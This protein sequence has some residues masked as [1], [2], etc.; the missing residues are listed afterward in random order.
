MATPTQVP[1]P[2]AATAP[3]QPRALFVWLMRGGAI[4]L[5]LVLAFLGFWDPNELAIVAVLLAVPF[6]LVAIRKPTAAI[7]RTGQLFGIVGFGMAAGV[8]IVA[9][10]DH[11]KVAAGGM[12]AVIPSLLL[13]VGAFAG[14]YTVPR[15]A[16]L[17]Q[18]PPAPAPVDPAQI[19]SAYG[20][21]ARAVAMAV[22]VGP[23]LA[24]AYVDRSVFAAYGV[25][26]VIPYLVF[27]LN[28]IR[29]KWLAW[30]QALPITVGIITGLLLIPSAFSIFEQKHLSRGD[31]A[32]LALLLTTF[33]LQPL[34]LVLARRTYGQRIPFA[35]RVGQGFIYYFCVFLFVGATLPSILPARRSGNESSAAGSLR[36]IA[37][38]A[39]NYQTQFPDAGYPRSLKVLGQC[40]DPATKDAACLLDPNLGC[41]APACVKSGYRF[42]YKPVIK[43]GVVVHYSAVARP[44]EYEETGRRSFYTDDSAVIRA[45]TDDRDANANDPPL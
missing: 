22:I 19:S 17:A 39:V 6:L 7:L 12:V 38:V 23:F 43:D 28:P 42:T 34:L 13:I 24:I 4:A 40:A 20:W 1:P 5:L 16:W 29:L 26:F 36:T 15:A 44:V 31:R 11:A 14:Y 2:P 3:P 8:A 41:P 37:T 27:L 35:G 30:G 25:L 32:W 33:V 45:T 9:Y 10:P 18:E 21:L